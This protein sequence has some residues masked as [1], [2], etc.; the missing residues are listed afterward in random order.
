MPG[1][2]QPASG[3]GALL[4][5]QQ[6]PQG[7]SP[8]QRV[9]AYMDQVKALH[10]GIDALA[11]DHPEAG[12]ELNTA[13]QALTNSLAKVASAMSSPSASPQPQTF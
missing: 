7:P 13:K 6:A 11:Q 5:P 10:D 4:G 3:I 1:Q 12:E 2:A 8:Q 9:Q